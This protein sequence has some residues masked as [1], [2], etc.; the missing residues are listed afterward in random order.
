[1]GQANVDDEATRIKTRGEAIETFAI[2]QNRNEY[3]CIDT[4]SRFL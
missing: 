1:M 2:K 3:I 4:E